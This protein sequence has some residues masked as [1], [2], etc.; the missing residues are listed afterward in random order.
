MDRRRLVV[1]LGGIIR[2]RGIALLSQLS[3]F[4][5]E[6]YSVARRTREI[7]IRM[8]LGAHRGDV[9]AHHE[10]RYVNRFCA[11]TRIVCLV[12]RRTY[13]GPNAL[14]GK[15]TDPIALVT[16]TNSTRCCVIA[17][18]FLPRATRNKEPMTALRT[19]KFGRGL[20]RASDLFQ[21]PGLQHILDPQ[22]A[23]I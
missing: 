20:W 19:S 22:F 1:R 9:Q 13:S 15:S 8:A 16:A 11:R 6:A 21:M 5:G 23:G 14:S 4:T 17:R 2:G 18:L 3:A 12:G 10:A 7:G